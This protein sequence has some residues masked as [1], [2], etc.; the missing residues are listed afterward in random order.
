MKTCQRLLILTIIG[1]CAADPLVRYQP[2][3][4]HLS[5][6][7]ESKVFVVLHLNTYLNNVKLY[8]DLLNN[9]PNL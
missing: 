9:C 4:I 1:F 2:E 3:Q 6:G 8:K 5:L 7:G